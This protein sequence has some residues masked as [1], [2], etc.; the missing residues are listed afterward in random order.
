M[1]NEIGLN[2]N[3]EKVE[4]MVK[5][6]VPRTTTEV[7]RFLGLCS[8]YRRFI[9]DFSSLVA[10]INAVLKNRKK[11]KPIE[12][13]EQADK[14]FSELKNKLVSAPVLASP[15]FSKQF[16]IQC[17]AS[18]V[19]L[20][21]VLTQNLDND[22]ERVIAFASRALTRSERNYSATEKECLAILFAVEKFRMYVEGTRF[23]VVTDHYS[24][25]WL[26]RLKNPSGRLARWA[27]KLDQFD[28]ELV[29]RKGKLNIVPDALS[30]SFDAPAEVADVSVMNVDTPDRWYQKLVTK[31][32]DNPEN[33][34]DWKLEGSV[35]YKLLVS[36][37][38]VPLN[39]PEWKMVIPSG[40]R[41]KVF[42]E[43]HDAREAGHFGFYKTLSK[44]QTKYYWPRLKQEVF[45]YVKKCTTCGAQKASNSAP[46]GIMNFE[47]KPQF[48]FEIV[49]LDLIG[50]LPRSKSG[51][52]W[53]LVISDFFLNM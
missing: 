35:L 9:K 36:P 16:V 38:P 39:S 1:I 6:P 40:N 47:K 30:R 27:L 10:P 19:G 20:G 34:P 3:P 43:C 45:A 52:R 51:I 21:A 24:L 22:G 31:V 37:F 33:Y 7:K 49:A 12:W 25:L 13:T 26:K 41:K 48:P 17:D 28:M 11:N 53:L 18:D 14:A 4:S 15:D 42:E 23:R 50:P 2:T 5:F 44:I 29:H 32:K 8:W 46:C